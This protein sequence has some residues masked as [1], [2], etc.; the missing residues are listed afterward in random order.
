MPFEVKDKL[1]IAIASSALFSLDEADEVFRTQGEDAYREHQRL[2]E[3]TCLKPGVA[4]AFI[5][6]RNRA[7]GRS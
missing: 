6:L 3:N 5:R 7:T 1:V 4:F 2:N